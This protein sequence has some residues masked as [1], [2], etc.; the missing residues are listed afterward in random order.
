VSAAT[1]DRLLRS[2]RQRRG[3]QPRAGRP[4]LNTLAAQVPIRTWG[5][6]AEE[7]PGALQGDLV[8]HCGEST[9]GSFIMTLVGV[10]VAT[11]WTELEAVWRPGQ[12]RIGTAVHHIRER[13]PMA[14]RAWHSDND[15]Q[16]INDTLVAWCRREGVQFTRGRKYRKNDQAY[17]E[18]RN[19]LAVRRVVG[20]ERYSSNAAFT[21]LQEVYRL[22]RL[23]LNFLRPLRKLIS[24]RRL[25]AQ[26]QKRYDAPRTPYQ[27]LC[28]AGVLSAARR[29]T[30]DAQLAAL[31]P[32]ALAQ[33]LDRALDRLWKYA[34]RR[35]SFR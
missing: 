30:L 21:A 35:G 29:Q 14:L 28:A 26:V 23:Q 22:L 20:Y 25:G 4:A 3:R 24:K 18:Q 7:A 33:A 17:V 8:L 10:D 34:D 1:I 9:G 13:L 32:I 6:W 27:R 11:G 2:V 15:G 12:H 19:W 31:D 16:F 5:E